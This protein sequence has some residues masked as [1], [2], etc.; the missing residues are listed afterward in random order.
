MFFYPFYLA[1]QS[2]R[3]TIQLHVVCVAGRNVIEKNKKIFFIN[4]FAKKK[5]CFFFK[6]TSLIACYNQ[7]KNYHY[8]FI[9]YWKDYVESLLT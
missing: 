1:I 4:F 2:F 9:I 3:G 6:I 8:I 7:A 5:P